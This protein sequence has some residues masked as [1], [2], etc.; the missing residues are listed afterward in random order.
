L[1]PVLLRF[2]DLKRVG[3]NNWPSLKRRVLQDN[4]P[5]GRYVGKNRVWTEEEVLDWWNALP[6]AEPP[7]DIVKPAPSASTEGSGRESVNKHPITSP[8]A[9]AAQPPITGGKR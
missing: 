1:L 8:E 4:F 3:I 9:S 7:P 5:T 2:R 6:K